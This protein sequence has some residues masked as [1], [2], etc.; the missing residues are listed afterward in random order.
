M[1]DPD[2]TDLSYLRAE[3]YILHPTQETQNYF[4]DAS[5]KA[6][7]RTDADDREQRKRTT[8][9]PEYKN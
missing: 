1:T 9:A 6:T 2:E 5:L 7:E 4:E 8:H 3:F